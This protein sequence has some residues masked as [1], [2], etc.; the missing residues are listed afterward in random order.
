MVF[1]HL[2]VDTALDVQILKYTKEE[3]DQRERE[4]VQYLEWTQVAH[5]ASTGMAQQSLAHRE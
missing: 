2:N 1:H 3:T 5:W 4:M